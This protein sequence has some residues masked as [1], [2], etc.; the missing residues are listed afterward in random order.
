MSNADSGKSEA[1][2]TCWS[3]RHGSL[4]AMPA[5]SQS[6][7]P[8]CVSRTSHMFWCPNSVKCCSEQ[9]DENLLAF[10]RCHQANR[11]ASACAE[12]RLPKGILWTR[13]CR[14]ENAANGAA[15]SQR[16]ISVGAR[17]T[18]MRR[19]DRPAGSSGKDT[20]ALLAT[21]QTAETAAAEEPEED[22]HADQ[23]QQS[24]LKRRK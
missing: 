24:S 22:S 15:I 10:P 9:L 20:S 2:C 4:A 7:Q 16:C 6:V 13:S 21:S 12:A 17:R 11:P 5:V 8:Q 19:H 1:E 23:S 18:C 14:D 3:A